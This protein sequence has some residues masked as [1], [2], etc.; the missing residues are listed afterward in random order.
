LWDAE[1]YDAVSSIQEGWGRK[2]VEWR[3]WQGNESVMDAGCGTGKL[4]KLLAQKVP[5][6]IVYAVDIDRNMIEVCARNLKDTGNVK[7]IE[8][9]LST[10]SVPAK[11]GVV[12]SNAAI[13]WILDHRKLFENFWRL[14]DDN[15]EI[16]IQCGG[17]GNLEKIISILDD[18]RQCDEFK[19]F[20]TSWKES[21]YFPKPEDTSRLLQDIGFKNINAY[22]MQD[23]ATFADRNSFALFT[24]TVVMKPYLALLPNQQK[25]KFLK[26]FLEEIET[27]HKSM[28]WVM[29]YVR[30][31]IRAIK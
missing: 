16:I 4:T 12:F 6:G 10:A 29:D 17:H 13:H 28:R 27:R 19:P 24:K 1:S 8:S 11:V 31:N 9:D 21:W 25:D 20:F 2:V 18:I 26:L 5:A 22:L 30:L 14:L 15:G 3:I 23:S 7:F